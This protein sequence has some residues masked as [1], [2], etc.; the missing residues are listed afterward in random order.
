[1]DLPGFG[2]SE[3]RVDVLSPEAMG[4]FIIKAA[5]CLGLSRLHAVGPDVGTAALLFAASSKS[6]LFESLVV[7]SG[8]VSTDLVAG[9]LKQLIASPIGAFAN[10]EGGDIGS[11]FVAASSAR[12]PPAAVID[13]YRLASAGHRFEDAVNYVRAYSQQLPRLQRLLPEIETPVFI[14]AGEHDPIV[15]PANGQLLADRLPH[16]RYSLLQGG[17]LIWEDAAEDYAAK[18]SQWLKHGYKQLLV[19][20]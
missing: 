3:G 8:G 15:P 19:A 18:V 13:D 11:S 20:K 7:G 12:K 5:D 17:H 16:N 6:T 2:H 9:D 10:I 1:M 4:E 14:I